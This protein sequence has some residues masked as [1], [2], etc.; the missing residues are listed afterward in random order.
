[1]LLGYKDN[2]IYIYY[3]GEAIIEYIIDEERLKNF[4]NLDV[5]YYKNDSYKR[6]ININ[7]LLGLPNSYNLS[8]VMEQI[9]SID[10]LYTILPTIPLENKD[11][12]D[13][14][15][16]ISKIKSMEKDKSHAIRKLL[17]FM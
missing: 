14:L 4:L 15:Y 11:D 2:G 10:E 1:Y 16:S 17:E 7:K 3:E 13:N 5:I 12:L 8:N 9:Y 6:Y